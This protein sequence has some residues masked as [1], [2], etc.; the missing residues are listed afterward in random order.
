MSGWYA[1]NSQEIMDSSGLYEKIAYE[2]SVVLSKK[3]SGI[4]DVR[5]ATIKVVDAIVLGREIVK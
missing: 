2:A 1:K 4:T 5:T 3:N